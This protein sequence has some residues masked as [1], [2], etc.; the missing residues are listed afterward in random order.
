MICRLASP[1]A[2]D[3]CVS[4][5][6]I[7]LKTR[8]PRCKANSYSLGQFGSTTQHRGDSLET[9]LT[10]TNLP[11]P[12]LRVTS[13]W[14]M[15]QDRGTSNRWL[16]VATCKVSQTI[17]EDLGSTNNQLGG[18]TVLREC[19]PKRTSMT[20]MEIK[21]HNTQERHTWTSS[22]ECAPTCTAQW[23]ICNRLTSKDTV[24]DPSTGWTNSGCSHLT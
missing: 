12:D 7:R 15:A 16:L 4:R 2:M 23:V 17:T 8:L 6:R 24:W 11:R 19:T 18:S 20:T 13:L 5:P 10:A 14:L 22:E 21:F 3:F 9:T 1:K